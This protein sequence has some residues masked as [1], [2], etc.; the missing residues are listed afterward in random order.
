[1]RAIGVVVAL[2]VALGAVAVFI[3]TAVHTAAW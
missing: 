2:V 1:M 3:G